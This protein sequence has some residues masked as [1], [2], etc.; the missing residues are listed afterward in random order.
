[1]EANQSDQ[2]T[3]LSVSS[4]VAG[5]YGPEG[6]CLSL[7]TVVRRYRVVRILRPAFGPDEAAAPRRPSGLLEATIAQIGDVLARGIAQDRPR[8]APA[9]EGVQRH[10][11]TPAR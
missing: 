1:V 11:R 9:R 2:R 6:V 10:G 7:P 8:R 4:L 3:V 5:R